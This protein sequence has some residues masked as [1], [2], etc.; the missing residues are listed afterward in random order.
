[1]ILKLDQRLNGFQPRGRQSR[2]VRPVRA[3]SIFPHHREMSSDR[4]PAALCDRPGSI[5]SSLPRRSRR[6]R[7]TSAGSAAN[8]GSG[9]AD[10]QFVGQRGQEFVLATVRLPQSMVEA[11]VFDGHGPMGQI[12][13][14]SQ[15]GGG[16]TAPESEVA[17]V[18]TLITAA[19]L[20]ARKD[21]TK[22]KTW[23]SSSY[24]A[25]ATRAHVHRKALDDLRLARAEHGADA[26]GRLGLGGSLGQSTAIGACRGRDGR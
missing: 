1:M 14:E 23:I 4:R 16:V 18:S 19:T 24:P 26:E 17:K 21:R 10:A 8:C 9:P 6:R 13:G 15:V 22:S 11:V 2:P 7:A 20:A 12:L 5:I 3:G 25:K